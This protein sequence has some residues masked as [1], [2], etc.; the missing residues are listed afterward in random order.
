MTS[1][2]PLIGELLFGPLLVRWFRVETGR[3]SLQ[4]CFPAGAHH[5]WEG[6]VAAMHHGYRRNPYQ[7]PLAK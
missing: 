3:S 2:P 5:S 4:F 7:T 1:L 6:A